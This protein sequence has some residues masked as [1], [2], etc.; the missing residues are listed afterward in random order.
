MKKYLRGLTCCFMTVEA[1]NRIQSLG[2]QQM[3]DR[4]LVSKRGDFETNHHRDLD[5]CTI[6]LSWC[7]MSDSDHLAAQQM[8]EL[9]A[10]SQRFMVNALFNLSCLRS[11]S[12][13]FI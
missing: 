12:C 8:L 3:Q 1:L 6:N 5:F 9:S 13:D 10:V 2:A 7:A 4:G 11:L